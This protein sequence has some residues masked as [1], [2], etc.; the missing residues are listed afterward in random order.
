MR[1][2]YIF[3]LAVI[4]CAISLF[5]A[6]EASAKAKQFS[7][8]LQPKASK[9]YDVFISGSY[10]QPGEVVLYAS[11]KEGSAIYETKGKFSDNSI[12]ATFKGLGKVKA[13]FK[14]KGKPETSGPPKGCTGPDSVSQEGTWTGKISFKGENGYT[15]VSTKKAPGSV[16]ETIGN[17][18]FDCG[19]G[20][21][22]GG[23]PQP[24]DCVHLS[25]TS[26]SFGFG[27]SKI[28]GKSPTFN[29]NTQETKDGMTISRFASAEGGTFTADTTAQTATLAPPSPF[30]GSGTFANDTLS[31]NLS[32]TLPGKTVSLSGEGF[33]SDSQCY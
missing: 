16:T 15:K 3:K 7:V 32:V 13:K 27:A 11:G 9:G 8:S 14:P 24:K 23:T 12:K 22:G 17:K 21:G 26:H 30:S 31:G 20:G 29:V 28:E 33:L 5:A 2:H 10:S 19:G 18:P 4:A 6:T 25:L 1:H